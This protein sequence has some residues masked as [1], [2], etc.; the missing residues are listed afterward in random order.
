MLIFVV[1]TLAEILAGGTSLSST[2]QIDFNHPSHRREEGAGPTLNLYVYDLRESKQIQHSGRQVDRK[3]SNSLQPATVNWSPSWFDVSILL[4]AWDR[5][6]LGEHHLLS[7]ALNVLLRHRSLQEDFLVPE[8]RGYGNLSMT[9]ALDPAIEIGSLW[10]ALNVPLR[11][12]LYLTVT[13]PF[14]PQPVP[15]PLVSER[16]FNLQNQF[17]PNGN[18][19]GSVA[20]K[21]V[22]IAGIV[23]SAVANQPLVDAK[24]A[25]LRT[26]KS[27]VSN[28]EG[29]F[30]FEDLRIGN[31]VL[32]VN[33]PG[34]L[35]QNVNVLVD[36][37]SY[38]FK[39]ILLTPE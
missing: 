15:V 33:C 7:E 37:P 11:A 18:G 6:A 2:E 23:K 4:T 1:Q 9:V 10:S 38:T 36:S 21:R 29:L 3:L 17:Y 31:Y 30:F 26:E 22:A 8:L 16:I 35:P 13:I 34:Y 32:T 19:N 24:V 20:T 12:G 28:Q 5:T 25:V 39:E 14:E 27:V